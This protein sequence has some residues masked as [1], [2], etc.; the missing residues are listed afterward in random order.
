MEVDGSPSKAGLYEDEQGRPI[1][2]DSIVLYID[3]LGTTAALRDLTNDDLRQVIKDH[4]ELGWFLHSPDTNE[5]ERSVR[6]S[7]NTVVGAPVS[8]DADGGTF[9]LAFSAATYQC[10]LAMRGRFVRGGLARGPLHIGDS[11]VTGEGLVTAV[12]LEEEE[13]VFPRVLVQRTLY[14]GMLQEAIPYLD[15]YDSPENR[16]V[17][18]DADG[19]LFVNYLAVLSEDG[20]DAVAAGLGQHREVVER[21][22]ETHGATERV[23]RKYAWVAQYHNWICSDRFYDMP[24]LSIANGLDDLEGVYPR[25]MSLL[26]PERGALAGVDGRPAD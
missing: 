6:F 2:K 14:L 23:R 9:H 20:D 10:N 1:L 13:A 22:L 11:Y 5:I 25:Q 4:S 7:D 19:E 24:E 15:P 12:K 18:L 3:E 17:L 21:M 26:I 16:F 8:E